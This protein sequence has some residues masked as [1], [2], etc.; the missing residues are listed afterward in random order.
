MISENEVTALPP[1]GL[2][3]RPNANDINAIIL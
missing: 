2:G 3:P 1:D